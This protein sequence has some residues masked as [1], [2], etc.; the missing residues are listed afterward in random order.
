MDDEALENASTF[1]PPPPH[2]IKFT[3]HNLRL[4]SLLQQHDATSTSSPQLTSSADYKGKQREVLLEEEDV[5]DWDLRQELLPPRVDW[6][7]EDGGYEAFG[8]YF[9]V[10]LAVCYACFR[11]QDAS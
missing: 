10:R 3:S 5:P 2:H 4:L 9:P 7:V 6:I 8:D 1:P 11:R